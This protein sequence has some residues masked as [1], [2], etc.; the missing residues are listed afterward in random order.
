MICIDPHIQKNGCVLW[1]T[2]VF[3]FPPFQTDGIV[4]SDRRGCGRRKEYSPLCGYR[5]ALYFPKSFTRGYGV[6][7]KA[8]IQ[9]AEKRQKV[10]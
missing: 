9:E 10:L 8:P 4:I 6:M 5:D 7:P 3:S 1:D 2:A